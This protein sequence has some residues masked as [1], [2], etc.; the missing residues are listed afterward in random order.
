MDSQPLSVA[1]GIV[2]REGD[3]LLI[4]RDANDYDGLWALPGGKIEHREHPLTAA[5]RE[6]REET[7]IQT[8]PVSYEATVSERLND[9]QKHFLLHLC[10][11]TYQ[12]GELQ[13]GDEGTARWHDRGSI[14]DIEMVGSDRLM[15]EHLVGTGATHATCTIHDETAS[16][17]PA[18]FTVH[19][20]DSNDRTSS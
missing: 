11:L 5:S 18:S 4:Q 16:D 12:G 20:P 1:L 13:N 7:G 19:S 10:K 15:L 9:S 2:E 6:I 8:E 3:I 17:G 14:D